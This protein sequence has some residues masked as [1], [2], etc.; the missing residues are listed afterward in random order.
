MSRQL[1]PNEV[2][3]DGTAVIIQQGNGK[4]GHVIGH[5][6]PSS[7]D[8]CPVHTV[9]ITAKRSRYAGRYSWTPCNEQWHGNYSFVLVMESL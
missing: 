3:P 6:L 1:Q 8:S 2:L 5:S 9:Q 7:P 4:R